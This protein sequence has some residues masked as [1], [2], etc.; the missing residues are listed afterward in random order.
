[1]SNHHHNFQNRGA[2]AMRRIFVL[3]TLGLLSWSLFSATSNAIPAFARKY[4]FNC[5]MCH[6][7]FTRL[8]DLGQRY[9]DNGYQ[10]PGQEGKEKTVF[11]AGPVSY[12]HLRAHE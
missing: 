12:T 8:N 3:F 6:S 9:R 4:G 2:L 5:N 10:I 11:D 7:G 1:M